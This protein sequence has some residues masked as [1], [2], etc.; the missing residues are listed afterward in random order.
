[1]AFRAGSSGK[2]TD[3]CYIKLQDLCFVVDVMKEGA[4]ASLV[5]S[6]YICQ[7]GVACTQ[8]DEQRLESWRRQSDLGGDVE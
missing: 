6:P 5:F 3:E 4:C 8:L 1:M 2:S 7:E